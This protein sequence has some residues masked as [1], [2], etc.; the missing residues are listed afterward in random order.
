MRILVAHN[1]HKIAGGEQRVFETETALLESAG[2][3]VIRFN[4]H[5]DEI[6]SMRRLTLA[7]K[8]M[9]N[10]ETHRE[11]VQLIDE[12][13]PDIVH[14]HNIVPLISPS[15]FGAAKKRDVKTVWTIHNYRLICPGMY[16][17]REGSICEKCV[18]RNL[19]LPAIRHKC[20]RNS[21]V[22]T[23]AV[24][25]MQA[26]H[27]A[28]GTWEK[29][30]DRFI[31]PSEFTRRKL[32]EGGLPIDR[33]VTKGNFIASVP[34][35][36]DG[37]SGA[38]VYVGRLSAEKGIQV[39]LDAW[40]HNG[41]TRRLQIVGRGPLEDSVHSACKENPSIEYLGPKS[42]SETM[43]LIGQATAAIVP[44][45]CYETFSLVAAESFAVG[46]PVIASNRGA[47]AELIVPDR[48]GV[49]FAPGDADAL[50]KCVLR[51]ESL[52]LTAMRTAARQ[53]YEQKHTAEANLRELQAIYTELL[54]G[55]V[56][57]ATTDTSIDQPHQSTAV[58][59]RD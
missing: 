49:L 6:D 11:L 19:A 29:S 48:N 34:S 5:N 59:A 47:L 8:T 25:T 52:D 51:F 1:S 17:M 58:V 23:T 42:H 33:L 41:L 45:T 30:V 27:L 3:T 21:R 50:A 24:V 28:I 35:I 53:S 13:H 9:W 43:Q 57:P 38:F 12:H 18:G 36:G 20:Y 54:G 15:I 2:H 39:L 14:A 32:A 44:S 7:V 31:A 22:A 16:L 56:E 40:T 46:T 55:R 37:S 26:L 4:V 10:R